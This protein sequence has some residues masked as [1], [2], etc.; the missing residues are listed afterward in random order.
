MDDG[1]RANFGTPDVLSLL[2]GGVCRA[3]VFAVYADRYRMFEK[4]KKNYRALAKGQPGSR[5]KEH[6]H[7][8]HTAGGRGLGH[9]I[10]FMGGGTLLMLVGVVFL[11]APGPG[12][13]I[14]AA[15]AALFAQESLALSGTLDRLEVWGRKQWEKFQNWRKQRAAR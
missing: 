10:L 8:L 5:F 3:G 4:I 13:V 2:G 7:R 1:L 12:M 15:G 9:K 6:Y 14:I 11:P